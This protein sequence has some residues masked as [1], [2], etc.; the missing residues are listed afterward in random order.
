MKTLYESILTDVESTLKQG[1]I[2]VQK[3]L[4]LDFLNE[5]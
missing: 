2:D 1:D 3:Q 4:V 5:E